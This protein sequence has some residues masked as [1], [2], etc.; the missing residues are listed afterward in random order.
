[1]TQKWMMMLA[2]AGLVAV[3]ASAQEAA[4]AVEETVD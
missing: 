2:V 3:Q 1:M 4:H